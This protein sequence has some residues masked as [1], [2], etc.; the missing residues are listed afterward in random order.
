MIE[1]PERPVLSWCQLAYL[2]LLGDEGRGLAGFYD[3]FTSQF[4]FGNAG[5][6]PYRL[7][8]YS[9]ND[10]VLMRNS[11]T[12]IGGKFQDME[13]NAWARYARANQHSTVFTWTGWA[14]G[15]FWIGPTGVTLPS[16]A[17]QFISDFQLASANAGPWN[18]QLGIVPQL[19]GSLEG[20]V[21]S[22]ALMFDARAVLLYRA[23]PQWLF[24][25]GA[26]FWDRATD[27]LIPY[28]GVIW[29][30]DD[31]WEFRFM[32]PRSRASYYVGR[33]QGVDTWTYAAS[34]YSLDAYQVNFE[35]PNVS[36]RGEVSDYRTFAG[37]TATTGIWTAF[38][39]GG[40]VTDRHFRF[41][42]AAPDFTIGDCAFLR[43]GLFF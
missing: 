6:Q 4:A 34:E 35:G 38:V 20:K 43:T 19:N 39:E 18:W 14:N 41:R 2:G 15:K 21:N 10:F 28:C 26:A 29:A 13:W 16:A 12:S 5:Q 27:R 9:Y 17:L 32:F 3:P 36:T 30:P 40:I 23:S 37:L 24:A 25:F 42:G 11:P 33:F 22:N 31:R 7:G 8:W 1:T